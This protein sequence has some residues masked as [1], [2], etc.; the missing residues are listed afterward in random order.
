MFGEAA[1][2]ADFLVDG[3]VLVEQSVVARFRDEITLRRVILATLIFGAG[4]LAGVALS[5]VAVRR[6]RRR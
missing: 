3:P 6:Q 1:S 4:A 5:L 2:I